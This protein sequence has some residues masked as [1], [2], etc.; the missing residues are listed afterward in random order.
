MKPIRLFTLLLCLGAFAL[1][2]TAQKTIQP[3]QYKQLHY[4][5]LRK[6]EIP[7][8]MRF[9]LDNGMIVYLLE[10][11]ALPTINASVLVRT[12]RRYEP[13][14]KVGLASLTG[15]VMRTG[16]TAS[17]TGDELDALL[18][19]VAASVETFIGTSSG[20]ANL[21]VMKEDIDLG[22]SVLADVLKNPAFR[23]DKIELAKITARSGISRRND[24]VQGI[25]GREFSRLIYGANHP[26]ARLTE[27][28][29]IENI[30]KQDMIDFHKKYFVPNN[31]MIALWGDF[32]SDAMRKKIEEAFGSWEKRDVSFPPVPQLRLASQKSVN[33]IKKDDVNQANIFIGHL[34]GQLNEP[35]SALL[36]LA[37]VAFGGAF[38]SRLFK[39]VRSEQGL[40]YNVGSTWGENYDYPG[41]FSISGSTKSNTTIKMIKSIEKEMSNVVHNGITDEE[42]KF[43]KDN[44]L[45]SFV[46]KYDT[47]GKI[48]RQLMTLE[49]YSYPKDFITKQQQETQNATKQSVAEAIRKRWKPELTTLLVVGKESDFDGPLSSLGMNIRTIDI[50][51]PAPPEKIPDPTPET[52][53]KGKDILK[54]TLA[55]MGGTKVLEI[56]D[57]T[58]VSK[59]SISM[60]QGDMQADITTIMVAPNKLMT[61]MKMPFGE[62][63]MAYDGVQGWRKTPQGVQDL[64]GSQ[65][66]DII[67]EIAGNMFS[68]LQNFEKP[69]YSVQFFKEEKTE[70]KILNVVIVR[71]APSNTTMRFFIDAQTNF[72]VKKNARGRSMQGPAD[73]EMQF[74]DYRDVNGVK[75]PF[76]TTNLADG[77]K[78]METIVSSATINSGIKPEL[79]KKP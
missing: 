62:M 33:F 66:E 79:F 20:G 70:G 52:I 59:M 69:D 22:L 26:Y 50:T 12:G 68:V 77:K 24:E 17:K 44:Y 65:R 51:I 71:H 30:T 53:A 43:A 72:I 32:S 31:M 64:P 75:V 19:K 34:G 1:P 6:I 46:F 29:T 61:Q 57:I 39:K 14:D 63:S 58:E 56:K 78:Q 60:G 54:K 15:Q 74:S 11:H 40:A 5:P 9:Q 38:A 16:G 4:P 25:A 42:L 47:K 67:K 49:Y 13:A 28:A 3:K 18:E 76:K 21:A 23:D 45:N 27:Y 7:E 41:I 2:A 8:P 73:I 48:I 10:D 36:N 37:D 35:E 55:A